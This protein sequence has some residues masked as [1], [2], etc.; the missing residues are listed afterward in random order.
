MRAAG[1]TPHSPRRLQDDTLL[2]TADGSLRARGCTL[3]VRIE[4]G[5]E[6]SSDPPAIITFKGPVQPGTMKVRDE[7]ETRAGSAATLL[8]VLDGIGLRAGFRYQK[9]R[10]EFAA[11]EVTI[12]IDETPVGVFV[13]LEGTEQGILA[14]TAALG[15]S[16]ADFIVASYYSLFMQRRAQ[17]GID[18]GHML[19]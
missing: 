8:R 2:D 14:M 10:E 6:A 3:R 1:A 9:Y 7:Q 5:G 11:P 16:P 18:A 15:R 19:F 13:E 12:A 4:G 17:F